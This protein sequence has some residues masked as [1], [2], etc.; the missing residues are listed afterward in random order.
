[1]CLPHP[2][3]LHVVTQCRSVMEYGARQ[4]REQSGAIRA[5][6]NEMTHHP[7]LVVLKHNL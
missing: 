2:S 5:T 1:M 7:L 6:V 3:Q 4:G